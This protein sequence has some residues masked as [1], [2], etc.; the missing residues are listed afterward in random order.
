MSLPTH[1]ERQLM[2]HLR[3]AG[4]VRSIA[5]PSSSKVIA[6]LLSKAGSN[7][8]ALEWNWFFTSPNRA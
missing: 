1:P 4:W 7:S 5:F 3:E 6:N 2:Q 8:V